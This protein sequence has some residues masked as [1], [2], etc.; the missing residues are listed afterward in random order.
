MHITKTLLTVTFLVGL[1]SLGNVATA[2][3]TCDDE[4]ETTTSRTNAAIVGEASAQVNDEGC[5]C[6]FKLLITVP[7]QWIWGIVSYIFCCDT[8]QSNLHQD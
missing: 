3:T 2:S 4:Q 1:L 8:A 6:S 7:S 5:W